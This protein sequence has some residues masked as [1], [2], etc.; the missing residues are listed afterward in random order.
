MM[1]VDPPSSRCV[2]AAACTSTG[3]GRR[4]FAFTLVEVAIVVAILGVLAGVSIPVAMSAARKHA[5]ESAPQ[6]I[7]QAISRARDVARD[8]LRCVTVLTRSA[9]DAGGGQVIAAYLHDGPSC[10]RDFVDA[11]NPGANA[12][13]VAE[14]TIAADAVRTIRVLRPE[15]TCLGLPPPV[16]CYEDAPNGRF[17]LRPDGTTDLPYRILLERPEG[18]VESFLIFPQTGTVRFE[19]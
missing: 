4:R 7:A 14:F 5:A 19:R 3:G 6:V 2:P 16:S 15:A 11:N 1:L 10:A 12:T 18:A 13:T 8:M 9:G 17:V